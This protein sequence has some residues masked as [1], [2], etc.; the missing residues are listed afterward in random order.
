[1]AEQKVNVN[2]DDALFE[3]GPFP[4]QVDPWS[5]L[6]RYFHP[7]H[8]SIIDYI[9][10]EFRKPLRQRGYLIGRETS[11]QIAQGR[12][13]DVFINLPKSV[14]RPTQ[15]LDYVRAAEAVNAEVG[16]VVDE[17]PSLD[18][19]K[20]RDL[21]D[22]TLVTIIELVSPSNK[23]KWE[24][25]LAYRLYRFHLVGEQGV[26][27][28]EVDLTRSVKRLL[29]SPQ[30][31]TYAYHA[32]VH[33][34]SDLPRLVGMAY[35][36][37]LKRIAVPLRGEVIALDLQAAYTHAYQQNSTS[38]WIREEGRYTEQ[39]LPFPSLLTEAQRQQATEAVARWENALQEQR[40]R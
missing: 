6:G 4:G 39:D 28:V 33:F 14:Q 25:V 22:N 31:E 19:L 16:V 23:E 11:L 20:I 18:A 30:A 24:Q 10:G 2:G 21:N 38:A 12:Q 37:P 7:I 35:G 34:P 40:P 8:E 5:E 9:L 15:T 13:P 27:V 32:A 29:E 17:S 36:E 3:Q 26:N 1:M